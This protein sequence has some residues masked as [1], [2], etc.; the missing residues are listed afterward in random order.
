MNKKV[1]SV[2]PAMIGYDI[3]TRKLYKLEQERNDKIKECINEWL[4]IMK[5]DEK[6][7]W[8]I[9]LP[10]ELYSLLGSWDTEASIEAA[11]QFLATKGYKVE[12]L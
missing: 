2:I 1:Y 12:K 10:S 7:F 6:K 8:T 9:G 11:K 3:D 5:Y 4:K